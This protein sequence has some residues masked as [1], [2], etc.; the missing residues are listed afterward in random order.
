MCISGHVDCSAGEADI[1][2]SMPEDS[3]TARFAGHS[4]ARWTICLLLACLALEGAT[5][6]SGFSHRALVARLA[7]GATLVPNDAGGSDARDRAIVLLKL[8][9]LL[10]AGVFWLTWLHRAYGNLALVGS[11]RSRF[12][13]GRAVGYW[14]IPLVNL[15]LGYQVMKDL[16][17]RSDSLNDRDGYDSLPAPTYLTGWWGTSVS[18][19][20]LGRLVAYMARDARTPLELTNATDMG[21]LVNAVGVVAA[22]LAIKVVWEIDRRQQCFGLNP[23]QQLAAAAQHSVTAS[24]GP[25]TSGREAARQPPPRHH[26]RHGERPLLARKRLR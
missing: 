12:S 16:W 11:K 1:A 8:V 13:R 9:A 21:M 2:P 24:P 17:L 3:S 15:V 19:G 23:A 10:G 22:L 20:V 25:R 18:W 14:F 4:V 5:M 7:A 26:P 6:A